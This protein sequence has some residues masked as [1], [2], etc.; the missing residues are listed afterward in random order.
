MV[1]SKNVLVYVMFLTH[2]HYLQCASYMIALDKPRGV[3]WNVRTNERI[4]I[5]IPDRDKF[6]KTVIKTITMHKAKN[7]EFFIET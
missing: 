3:L 6:V 4:F 2:E 1:L 5:T 7:V